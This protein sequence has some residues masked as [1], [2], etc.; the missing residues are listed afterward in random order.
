MEVFETS[1]VGVTNVTQ[2]FLPLLRKRDEDTTKKILNISSI[3]GSIALSIG[4]NPAHKYPAY[5]VAKAGLNMHTKMMA[6]LLSNE[7]FVVQSSHPGWV[8]TAMGGE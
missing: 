3:A 2:A 6:H 1:V 5:C 4:L 8:R 7:K